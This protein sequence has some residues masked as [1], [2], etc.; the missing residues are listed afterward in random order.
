MTGIT[1]S[2]G[3]WEVKAYVAEFLKI[4]TQYILAD[5]G[6][7]LNLAI[8]KGLLLVARIE[9]SFSSTDF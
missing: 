1:T 5:I 2:Y 3:C 8:E 7:L 6:F 4:R 9:L